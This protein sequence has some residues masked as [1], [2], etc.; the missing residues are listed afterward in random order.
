MKI[1]KRNKD[2]KIQSWNV[3]C[4]ECGSELEINKKDLHII[5]NCE[6]YKREYWFQCPVCGS[7]RKLIL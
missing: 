6:S 7:W 5:Y 2:Y 3:D 4:G 1:R